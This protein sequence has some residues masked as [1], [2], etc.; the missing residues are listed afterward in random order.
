M[1]GSKLNAPAVGKISVKLVWV[2]HTFEETKVLETS[3]DLDK[4][5]KEYKEKGPDSFYVC[6]FYLNRSEAEQ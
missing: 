4:A 6:A 1:K 5:E 2:L 3:V